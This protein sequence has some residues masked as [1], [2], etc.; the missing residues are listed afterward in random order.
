MGKSAQKNPPGKSPRKSSQNLYNK[1]PPTHFCRM[2]GASTA[3]FHCCVAAFGKNDVRTTEKQ[4]LQCNFCSATRKCSTTSVC[5]CGMLQG[6]GLEGWGLGLAD[7]ICICASLGLGPFVRFY[8]YSNTGVAFFNGTLIPHRIKKRVVI[9]IPTQKINTE[10]KIIGSGK[11]DPVQLN[12]GLKQ[13][14]FLL[15]KMGVVQIAS[16]KTKVS[17]KVPLQNPFNLKLDRVVFWTTNIDREN[18]SIHNRAPMSS[19]SSAK[20]VR[21][22]EQRIQW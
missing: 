12:G 17:S 14:P 1:N 15:V 3:V 22:T 7:Q 9:C 6:F 11:I 4:T 13:G 21:A 16:K 18:E 5:A 2:A 8:A 19:F 10:F 20:E